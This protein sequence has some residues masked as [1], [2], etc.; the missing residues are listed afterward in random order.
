[1]FHIRSW[2]RGMIGFV[3]AFAAAGDMVIFNCQGRDEPFDPSP[4]SA[5]SGVGVSVFKDL[6][7]KFGTTFGVRRSTCAAVP[8]G[9]GRGAGGVRLG[10]GR[11]APRSADAVRVPVAW[12]LAGR[13][14][15]SGWPRAL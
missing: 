3:H 7:P 5:V 9:V 13:R 12:P 2:P 8:G 14:R 15:C 10:R 1:M 6:G 11:D 4:T